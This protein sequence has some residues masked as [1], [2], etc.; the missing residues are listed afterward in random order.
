[1]KSTFEVVEPSDNSADQSASWDFDGNGEADALTD[2]LLL[3]R[4]AFNLR[5]EAL[6]NGAIASSSIMSS[7]EVQEALTLAL[8]IADIDANGEVDALTDGLLLLRYL[9]NLRGESLVNGAIASGASRSS[10][11]DIEEYIAFTNAGT[12][13]R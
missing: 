10:D 13:S 4:Y 11:V 12:N 6:T 5:D 7:Q 9:F 3:L 8:D 2:G 1:M